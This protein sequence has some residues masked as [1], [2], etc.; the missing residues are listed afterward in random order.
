MGSTYS[1][2]EVATQRPDRRCVPDVDSFYVETLGPVGGERRRPLQGGAFGGDA[3]E[4]TSTALMSAM[5]FLF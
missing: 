2:A 4:L 3:A 1:S 5:H